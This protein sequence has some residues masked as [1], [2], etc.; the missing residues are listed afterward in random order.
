MRA[1]RLLASSV[2]LLTAASLLSAC[3]A[4]NH[5]G[6]SAGG[7]PVRGGTLT[8]GD[9]VPPIWPIGRA[10]QYTQAALWTNLA[11]SLVA[12]DPETG[13]LVAHLATAWTADPTNTEFTFTIR[14]GVTFSDGSA[15]TPQVVV[16]NFDRWG[17]GDKELGF[18]PDP[19]FAG[20]YESAS[21]TGDVVTVKLSKPNRHVLR[22]L[23]QPQRGVTSEAYLKLSLKEQS[24][25]KNI[26]ASGPFVFESETPGQ[27]VVLTRR[28][29]YA[30]PPA[31]VENKDE[32]YLDK[33]VI[34]VI[35]ELGLRAQALESDQIQAAT[36]VLPTDE[37]RLAQQ[38]FVI[39]PNI[40]VLASPDSYAIRT[41]NPVLADVRVRKALTLGIDRAALSR[42]ALSDSYAPVYTLQPKKDPS[43][44]SFDSELAY[45]PEEAK[46]LLDEAGWRVGADGFREK[47]GKKLE[48]T[49][50]GGSQGG[51]VVDAG[52]YLTQQWKQTLG[53]KIIDR[54]GDD[55]FANS[56]AS[57]P[58]VGLRSTRTSLDTG[59]LT[60]FG[61][62]NANNLQDFPEL[63][64]LINQDL[65]ATDPEQIK[66]LVRKQLRF[67]LIDQVLS[68]PLYDPTQVVAHSPRL[69]LEF[70]GY[71]APRFQTAWLER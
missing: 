33:V 65:A 57:D 52:A 10:S 26:V 19:A 38:G 29:G 39:R 60:A 1:G 23:A 13:E 6:S 5:A 44:V 66:E 25:P 68:I 54:S 37:S 58:D 16:E 20:A 17:K 50:A 53:V 46:R 31:N 14:E 24:D 8:Y 45:N 7:D 9:I 34:K 3:S 21:A 2:A 48:I 51:G 18:T 41:G 49:L 28:D 42:D 12:F 4:G 47:D 32:A 64:E 40:A 61:P 67:V 36:R 43:Y 62:G 27:E 63:I 30:W 35:P 69:H 71:T 70:S 59:Q 11:D 56:T 22:F 55:T 15:L